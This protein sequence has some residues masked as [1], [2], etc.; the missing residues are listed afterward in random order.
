MNRI[1]L[2]TDST[3][4]LTEEIKNEY[5]IHVV[6]L[7]VRF[8]DQEYFDYEITSEEFY[9]RLAQESQLPITSQPSPEDFSNIYHEL[10]KDH[11]EIISIHISSGLSGTLNA[12]NL[13]KEG[14]NGRI[15]II[16]SKTISLGIGLMVAEAARNIREGLSALQVVDGLSKVRKNIETLFTLNTLEYLQKGGRI[17]KV[18]GI[19][20]SLLNIKPVVRVGDDGI[21]HTYGK[22]RSQERALDSIVQAFRDLARGR[23]HIR[24]AVAHGAA[25]Q[26]GLY[27]KEALENA[28]QLKTS[29]FTQVGPVIG[30]HTGPGTIG[31][32]VQFE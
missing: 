22:T 17:G 32:A 21:Y 7:K 20:G 8:K 13:A 15:H 29:V 28:L 5:D 19:V 24:L 3:A 31:A 14:L 2:V 9:R 16:D 18:Q 23:K 27:L 30:V 11:D 26:A 12:A 1:A 4:D 25:Q 10:L 6:P